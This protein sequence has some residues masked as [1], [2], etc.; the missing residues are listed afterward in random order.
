MNTTYT[1]MFRVHVTHSYYASNVC[2][3][4]KYEAHPQTQALMQ[5]YGIVL[6]VMNSGFELFAATNQTIETFLTYISQVSNQTSFDF[7]ATTTTQNFY[8]FT[9]V[10]YNMLGT[11]TYSSANI[12]NE[13]SDGILLLENFEANS[14]AEK[15]MNVSIQFQDV[16]SLQKE[17]QILQFNIQLEARSTQWNYFIIQNS[18]QSYQELSIQSKDRSIHFSKPQQTTLQNGQK[19]VCFSSEETKIP[20]H[21]TIINPLD[22]INTK[23]TASGERNEIIIKGLPIP[24]PENLQIQNDHT[25]ASVAYVYI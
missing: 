5:K 3:C 23:K 16:I 20:L 24:N 13:S 17:N 4:F 6:H 25:I 2:E 8:N 22:L 7:W 9:K 1:S 12:G 14:S 19:A 10:P 18:D 11:L 21:D 15:A